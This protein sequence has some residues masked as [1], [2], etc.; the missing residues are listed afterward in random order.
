ML[1]T[2]APQPRPLH[3]WVKSTLCA[4]ALWPAL[5]V[6]KS[7]SGPF[8]QG[9]RTKVYL[10]SGFSNQLQ[11]LFPHHSKRQS[12][13]PWALPQ[14]TWRAQVTYKF[15]IINM[16]GQSCLLDCLSCPGSTMQP[17][18]KAWFLHP[19]VRPASGV[20]SYRPYICSSPPI[21]GLPFP[22]LCH[23]SLPFFSFP[24]LL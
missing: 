3:S 10:L 6:T 16:A 11:R 9:K 12:A 2:Q 13:V 14:P 24:I 19:P 20:S 4:E 23:V 17:Q 8:P 22:L 15:I 5:L 1:Q 7:I 18:A 21:L